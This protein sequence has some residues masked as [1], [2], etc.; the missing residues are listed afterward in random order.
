MDLLGEELSQTP[1]KFKLSSATNTNNYL[2]QDELSSKIEGESNV[3]ASK[4]FWN[5][6]KLTNN[7]IITDLFHGQFRSS[8]SCL[9]C[10]NTS[11]YFEPFSTLVLEIPEMKKVDFLLVS[12]HFNL[13]PVINLSCFIPVNA[14]F[15]DIAKFTIN[16]Y[17]KESD[18]SEFEANKTKLKCLLVNTTTFTSR[19]VKLND[20]IYQTSKRGNIVIYEISEVEDESDYY[21]YICMLRESAEKVEEKKENEEDV[22]ENINDENANKENI[23]SNSNSNL[24]VGDKENEN[25]ENNIIIKLDNTNK[26]IKKDNLNY[27]YNK[28]EVKQNPTNTKEKESENDFLKNLSF[29]RLFNLSLDKTVRD[30]RT[31]LYAFMRKIYQFDFK[32][33][34]NKNPEIIKTDFTPLTQLNISKDLFTDAELIKNL[35]ESDYESYVEEEFK[36]IFVDN[37]KEIS[38]TDFIKNFPYTVKLVS[39]KDELKFKILFSNNPEEFNLEFPSELGLDKFNQYIKTGYK[40]VLEFK[41]SN[42]A[43]SQIKNE[44]NKVI[45]IHPI[46]SNLNN[47]NSELDEN[48]NAQNAKTIT[49]EDCLDNFTLAEKLEK[50]NEWYCSSCKKN[51]NSLKRMELYYIPKNLIIMLKRFDTKM[52]SKTKIQI[53]KNNNIVKYP[54]NNLRLGKYFVSNNFYNDNNISYDL[55]AISQHSGSLEGG[56]YA[57]ACRNFGKWYELD[58][59]TVFPSDEET[60]VSA[61]GYILF[62]RRKE[63]K[64]N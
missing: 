54:V 20:N 35:N 21:P 26:N 6:H 60:V 19:F 43:F 29:P 23:E 52:I 36:Y 38:Q 22:R 27:A 32:D 10:D 58:D 64:G 2:D 40:L 31:N 13:K 41:K 11:V 7:S 63:N 16:K 55:Y 53:W 28:K 59:A 4:R 50:G 17:R 44:L 51:Q 61:E 14:L 42:N 37:F 30:L 46:N 57:A 24:N 25:M 62:Y 1:K 47:L 34:K 8:I 5:F 12:S 45:S 33:L 3:Q 18:L 9:V 39:A 48:G 15:K 56:H 49:L